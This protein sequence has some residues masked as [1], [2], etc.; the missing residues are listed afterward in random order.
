[1]PLRLLFP[2]MQQQLV[3]L[4][5]LPLLAPLLEPL[6]PLRL[7]LPVPPFQLMLPPPLP[8]LLG[9]QLLLILQFSPPAAF[10]P[11]RLGLPVS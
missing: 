4:L 3:L 2:L 8:L 1:M 9:Q 10:L 6:L 11:R 5:L 7:L